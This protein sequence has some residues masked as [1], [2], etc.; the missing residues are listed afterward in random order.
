MLPREKKGSRFYWLVGGPGFHA[1]YVSSQAILV[2]NARIEALLRVK[3]A[4]SG[5][6]NAWRRSRKE[7]R[8][9]TANLIP[10]PG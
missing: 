7:A 1:W 3:S 5:A 6:G 9:P 10:D 4:D 8:K 2:S